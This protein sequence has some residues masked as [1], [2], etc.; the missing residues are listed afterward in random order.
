MNKSVGSM[1]FYILENLGHYQQKHLWTR[2]TH[3]AKCVRIR[4]SMPRPIN[5]SYQRG[6]IH[7]VVVKKGL[8][9]CSTSS[10]IG[11]WREAPRGLQLASPDL[12]RVYYQS[13]RGRAQS[14]IKEEDRCS[15]GRSAAP[16]VPCVIVD[17]SGSPVPLWRCVDVDTDRTWRYE[18]FLFL[19]AQVGW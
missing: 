6:Y 11:E 7:W 2:L 5:Y 19:S 16:I 14:P 4:T 18:P 17:W 13:E 9:W 12:F 8:L 15:A 1:F 3:H 10:Y